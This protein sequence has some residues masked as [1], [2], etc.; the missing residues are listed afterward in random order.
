MASV[1][2]RAARRR[3]CTSRSALA[4][5]RRGRVQ[6][7]HR[8]LEDFRNLVQA[9]N[10]GPRINRLTHQRAQADEI[11]DDAKRPGQ[12]V[13]R[14]AEPPRPMRHDHLGYT[15]TEL[16]RQRRQIAMHA[17]TQTQR[18]DDLGPENLQR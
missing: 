17:R 18:L 14:P 11:R 13:L 16:T 1:Y 12:T 6:A 15:R 7:T 2:W 8:G 10:T 3:P 5:V 9:D 4:G